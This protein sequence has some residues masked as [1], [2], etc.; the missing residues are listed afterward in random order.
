MSSGSQVASSG[1]WRTSIALTNPAFSNALFHSRMPSRIGAIF[2]GNRLLD[3]ED[4]R[5]DRRRNRFFGL[6]LPQVPAVDVADELVGFALF[7]KVLDG[8]QKV[9]HAIV[10]LPG[11]VAGFGQF[12]ERIM[13]VDR[14]PAAVGNGVDLGLAAGGEGGRD[15]QFG[16]VLVIL[17]VRPS[18]TVGG[19]R[20][21]FQDA[22][23][24]GQVAHED[25]GQID[26]HAAAGALRDDR[27]AEEDAV[28]IGEIDGFCGGRSLV[29]AETDVAADDLNAVIHFAEL[30]NPIVAVSQGHAA[31][32][33]FFGDPPGYRQGDDEILVQIAG[34]E[35]GI[36]LVFLA[37]ELDQAFHLLGI[38][39]HVLERRIFWFRLRRF[40]GCTGMLRRGAGRIDR[41]LGRSLLGRLF[42]CL[43]LVLTGRFRLCHEDRRRKGKKYRKG[44]LG[45]VF[46]HKMYSETGHELG[47]ERSI[48][49]YIT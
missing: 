11:L 20:K 29:R 2:V 36:E 21:S 9:T 3:P 16:V 19:E 12:A 7:G 10:G 6:R 22:R 49:I 13:D 33:R 28:G 45:N 44:N 24:L 48:I 42:S 8:R 31:Q 30:P 41:G 40:A 5:C 26:H 27:Q 46:F 39:Q 4:D 35:F 34:R 1:C 18:R 37:I 23:N 32:E 17:D 15:F 43:W 14:H 38:T 25:R 47:K